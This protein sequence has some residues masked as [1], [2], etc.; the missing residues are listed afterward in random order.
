MRSPPFA[1]FLAV[2][3]PVDDP[4]RLTVLTPRVMK[5]AEGVWLMDLSSCRSYWLAMAQRL[6]RQPLALV[7]EVLERALGAGVAVHPRVDVDM[8]VS[9]NNRVDLNERAAD[10][11]SSGGPSGLVSAD[12][13]AS[14]LPRLFTLTLTPT[15]TSV[16]ATDDSACA[17]A[18]PALYVVPTKLLHP[19]DEPSLDDVPIDPALPPYQVSPNLLRDA[20]RFAATDGLCQES[21]AH[22]DPD[23]PPPLR[24]ALADHP[25]A[26]V[27][28][29]GA[30]TERRLTGFLPLETPF[31]QNLYRGIVWD[32]WLDAAKAAAEHLAVNRTAPF[33]AAS[34][35]RDCHQL[36]TSVS[37]L[38]LAT[39]WDLRAAAALAVRR[40]F[41]ATL[42]TL[43]EWTFPESPSPVTRNAALV[44]FPWRRWEWSE[45]P[46]VARV[47]EH[48]LWQWDALVPLLLE[49]LDK[50]LA[51]RL[52]TRGFEGKATELSWTLTLNDLRQLPV[53]VR[54][55]HPHDLARE[56]GHHK[57][58]LLQAH[59]AFEAAIGKQRRDDDEDMEIPI[60][61]W[62]LALD[63][64]LSTPP[65]VADLFGN[66]DEST[67]A[68][69]LL[70]LENQLPVALL[71]YGLC[72]DWLP[73]S[74]FT[75]GEEPEER[76]TARKESWAAS[77]AT[78][79][80][81]SLSEADLTPPPDEPLSFWDAADEF[82]TP[83]TKA[84]AAA[85]P[86]NERPW[87][88][89]AR[90]RPLFI[91]ADP[92]PLDTCG[93]SSGRIF[94]ERTSTK[95]WRAATDKA[96]HRDYYRLLDRMNRSAWIFQDGEGKWFVQGV[97]A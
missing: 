4:A 39:P 2:S 18:K 87:L 11:E 65:G 3:T 8:S 51:A 14:T 74:S 83:R 94:I 70:E 88:I 35:R 71:Q 96:E 6:Q 24:A 31:A 48:A 25:W 27:L 28:L 41:G 86:R 76:P 10:Q 95:W 52:A 89:A 23:A 20:A 13:S 40:R 26:A 38:R 68:G 49:D 85:P 84:V 80:P 58:A 12:T 91:H 42:A 77:R 73:E 64:C 93:H 57:T 7:R 67:E 50:L 46:R 53:V 90:Q 82:L 9:V 66:S 30:M 29:L 59:Y 56:A 43:W 75:S 62:D 17:P 32:D 60:I 15:P 37:R 44:S 5:W 22:D 63:A 19:S 36:K 21:P 97:F 1:D 45:K 92:V 79:Y 16:S 34:F 81:A 47:L 61:A 78:P 33:N 55:R 72:Q 54:F 69:R